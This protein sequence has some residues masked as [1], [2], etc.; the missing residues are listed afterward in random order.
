MIPAIGLACL[1]IIFHSC[2]KDGDNSPDFRE[3][4]VGSYQVKERIAC[5][6]PCDTCFS[7]KDTVIIVNYG[8]TDSTLNVLGR[9]VC[10]D[11]AGYYASYHYG[12]RFWNDS[13]SSFYMNGGLGC[14][15][16]ETYIGTRI[17]GKP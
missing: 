15:Q 2:C 5:Y 16:Y 13:I 9:D 12:L 8:L 14:G 4:Y 17:S 7:E 1:G 10:L 11:T 6:G 3:K